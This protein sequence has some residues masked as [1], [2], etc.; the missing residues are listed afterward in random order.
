MPKINIATPVPVNLSVHCKKCGAPLDM[1]IL[2]DPNK[3]SLFIG[4]TPGHKCPETL[5]IDR[6]KTTKKDQ[7][8]CKKQ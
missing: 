8:L 2:S 1:I 3:Q 7:K 4:I 6:T 5:T